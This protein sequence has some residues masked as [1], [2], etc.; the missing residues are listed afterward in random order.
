M[1]PSVD[2]L[3]YSV[4]GVGWNDVPA[5]QISCLLRRAQDLVEGDD[6]AAFSDYELQDEKFKARINGRYKKF[7][8][9]DVGGRSSAFCFKS[10]FNSLDAK[11]KG[12]QVHTRSLH[13]EENAFL[14]IS[15]YGG[16]G[17]S[18]GILFS[19]ASPCELCSKK[20]FQL[21]ITKIYYIDPYPGI[22]LNHILSSGP[23]ELRPKVIL[24]QGA[25]GQAF[26]KLY[27]PIL[28]FK[29]EIEAFIAPVTG[30]DNEVASEAHLNAFK[31]PEPQLDLQ[32]I[33]DKGLI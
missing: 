10:E 32:Q 29:D 28:P 6:V 13:A 16:P 2:D 3:S 17:L 19:T 9:I 27:D 25:V 4:K 18:G 20:A 1:R 14:Q 5:G 8:L 7:S 31:S 26:H 24:F 33:K 11:N 22:S 12:N 21:G 15:K 30:V 23:Q